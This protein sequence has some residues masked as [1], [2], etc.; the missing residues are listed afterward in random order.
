MK[1]KNIDYEFWLSAIATRVREIDI[2]KDKYFATYQLY[3]T[4]S[5]LLLSM[6]IFL[7]IVLVCVV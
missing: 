1:N 6:I 3:A 7:M 4:L 5:L 2:K